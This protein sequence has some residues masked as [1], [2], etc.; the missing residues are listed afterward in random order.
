MIIILVISITI[1]LPF[2]QKIL[3]PYRRQLFGI[4]HFPEELLTLYSGWIKAPSHGD[5]AKAWQRILDIHAQEV[6]T[7]GIVSQVPQP[8]LVAKNLRNV[9]E[10]GIYNWEPGAQFGIYRPETFW[11]DR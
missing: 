8:V 3:N 2:L 11:W 4:S 5:R 6:Y 7:I 1:L 9:P 10:D